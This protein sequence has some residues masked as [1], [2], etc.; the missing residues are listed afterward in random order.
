MDGRALRE[1]QEAGFTWAEGTHWFEV[2]PCLH[3]QLGNKSGC[4]FEQL[5]D[6]VSHSPLP[7]STGTRYCQDHI[8][9]QRRLVD[10]WGI[11]RNWRRRK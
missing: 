3:E 8:Q 4:S 11:C 1:Q 6:A 10:M 7:T 9:L 5:A 2:Y